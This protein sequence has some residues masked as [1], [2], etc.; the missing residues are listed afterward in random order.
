M[1]FQTGEIFSTRRLLR[2]YYWQDWSTARVKGPLWYT[3][4][5]L[6]YDE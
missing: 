5:I 6:I 1:K 4:V 2:E 3:Q